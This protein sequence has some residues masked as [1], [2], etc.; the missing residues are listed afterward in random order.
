MCT[1]TKLFRL[2]AGLVA[3]LILC[4]SRADAAQVEP[5]WSL[6]LAPLVESPVVVLQNQDFLAAPIGLEVVVLAR[7]GFFGQRVNALG[8]SVPTSVGALEW[9]DDARVAH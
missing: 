2:I 9:A 5:I 6:P 3:V 7:T 4:V 8:V 1:P